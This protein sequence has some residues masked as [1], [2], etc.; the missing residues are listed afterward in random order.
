MTVVTDGKS[1]I[2]A[3]C[4]YSVKAV[5]EEK[6]VFLSTPLVFLFVF[7]KAA[8]RNEEKQVFL[9]TLLVFCLSSAKQ[10]Y[11]MKE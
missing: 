5:S 7:C 8:V 6:Q 10:L 9:S 2:S 3:L 4:W 1:I 11:E